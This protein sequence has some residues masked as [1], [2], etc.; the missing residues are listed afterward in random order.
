MS[1]KLEEGEI[2]NESSKRKRPMEVDGSAI[3]S[4]KR[5]KT[6]DDVSL[7][8]G[9]IKVFSEAKQKHYYCHPSTEHTQWHFP[10]A[11]EAL[12]LTM[13]KT[14]LQQATA[15]K[16]ERTEEEKYS[17]CQQVIKYGLEN[18]QLRLDTET[19]TKKFRLLE[20][21]IVRLTE[22][23]RLDT[24][25]LELENKQLLLDTAT[26][27]VRLLEHEVER[28]TEK[29]QLDTERLKLENEKFQRILKRLLARKLESDTNESVAGDIADPMISPL[30]LQN[31]SPSTS[32]PSTS[33][34]S[35]SSPSTSSPS[36]SSVLEV[37]PDTDSVDTTI[38]VSSR[39][40]ADIDS[41]PNNSKERHQRSIS[42][43]I[44][45]SV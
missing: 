35:T 36:T 3:A 18:K 42:L 16:V 8:S 32:S 9:W 44:K 34:P 21:E 38:E 43:K 26:K 20:H 28:L 12:D 29:A 27:K 14:R 7:P 17:D 40:A 1:P 22:K 31:S 13:A 30:S 23:A 45:N 39:F 5:K 6:S 19:A 41:A 24:K 10:A 2:D 25:R 37:S 33:S 11:T 4:D 15:T